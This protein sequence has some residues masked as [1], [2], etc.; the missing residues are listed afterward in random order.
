MACEHS[1]ARR[2]RLDGVIMGIG[3]D[4]VEISRLQVALD[5]SPGLMDRLF[6]ESEQALPPGSLAGCFATKEAVAKA[7]GAP[8]GL[9]WTD[10]I[11]GRDPGGRPVLE[12]RGTVAAAAA[13]LGITRWHVSISHD[14]GI[15]VAMVVAEGDPGQAGN[16][17]QAGPAE[18]ELASRP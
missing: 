15:C 16:R 17:D 8:P 11:A 4:V 2:G 14:A 12:T 13:R 10:A 1:R 9:H 5:R 7:L 18:G 6:T 3:V